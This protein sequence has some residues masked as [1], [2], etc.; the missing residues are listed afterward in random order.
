M[1]RRTF[2]KGMLG[3]GLASLTGNAGGCLKFTN[4]IT[5]N[6]SSKNKLDL[7]KWQYR[8]YAGNPVLP[9]GAKGSYDSRRCMNPF[10]VKRDDEYWM[11]YS[12]A[13]D[14][15]NQRICLAVADVEQPWEFKRVGVVLELGKKG[16]FDDNWC[17]LPG[18]KKVNDK[19]YLYYSGRDSSNRGLQS[20]RGIGLAVSNDGV[21][22]QRYSDKPIITGNNTK[23]YPGNRGIAGGGSILTETNS[24]GEVT[25][26]KYYTLAV[27]TK[28]SNV[29]VDQEKLCAV[30]RSKDGIV[31]TDHRVI[32]RRRPKVSNEDIAV[33]APFV[34]KD[35][36]IYRMLYCGIG[37]RWGYYSC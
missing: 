15:H 28:N 11:Y 31:W 29:F 2:S 17:V 24:R 5:A 30:C 8:R 27:G 36:N 16:E 33:A 21:N 32:M 20:F 26:R 10:V 25:F 3:L 19:W 1:N 6:D 22:F 14:N 12:G 18:L 23:E 9:P 35:D 34:W 7:K 37:S 13:D 4:D